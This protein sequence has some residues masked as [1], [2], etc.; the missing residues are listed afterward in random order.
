MLCESCGYQLD[1]NVKFCPHC[2]KPRRNRRSNVPEQL[3]YESRG[4]SKAGLFQVFFVVVYTIVIAA[5]IAWCSFTK[6][7]VWTSIPVSAAEKKKFAETHEGS[8][9]VNGFGTKSVDV[10]DA[11]EKASLWILAIAV[12]IIGLLLAWNIYVHFNRCSLKVFSQHLEGR[13][14]SWFSTQVSSVVLKAS[15]LLSSS[16]RGKSAIIIKTKSGR[17]IYFHVSDA[18]ACCLAVE[19]VIATDYDSSRMDNPQPIV[20]NHVV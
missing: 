5:L 18:R 16:R 7:K 2:G 13:P 6:R 3:L 10:F 17:R 20:S 15:E 8:I 1:P 9:L 19:Q 4:I 12:L 11:D 14:Y